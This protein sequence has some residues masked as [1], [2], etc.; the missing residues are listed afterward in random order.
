MTEQVVDIRHKAFRGSLEGQTVTIPSI[1]KLLPEW[2]PNLH[3]EYERA[4][5]ETLD[6]WIRRYFLTVASILR[7]YFWLTVIIDGS[8]MSALRGLSVQPILVVLLRF[9]CQIPSPTESFTLLPNIS[10]GFVLFAH[11]HLFS[12]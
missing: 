8:L 5:D 4:R 9:G 2:Q 7:R 12:G 6:P 10:P 11:S 3:E 1:Y